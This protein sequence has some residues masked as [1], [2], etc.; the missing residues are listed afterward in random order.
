MLKAA[1][2]GNFAQEN[3]EVTLETLRSSLTGLR[4][5]SHISNL[6]KDT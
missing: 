3:V 1:K 6:R 5:K 4:A 2:Y